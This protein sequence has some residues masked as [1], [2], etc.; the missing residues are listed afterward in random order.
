ME[1]LAKFKKIL[2]MGFRATLNFRKFKKKRKYSFKEPNL[3][4]VDQIN[5]LEIS[6]LMLIYNSGQASYRFKNQL[7]KPNHMVHSYGT[8]NRNNCYISHKSSRL[9]QYSLSFQGPKIWNSI[10]NETK[11]AM[12]FFFF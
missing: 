2:Y 12:S 5:E 4:R 3:L 7:F 6:I 8:R 1:L 10:D 9:G 11:D